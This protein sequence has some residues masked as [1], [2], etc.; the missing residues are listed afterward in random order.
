VAAILAAI[1]APSMRR[2]RAD[3]AAAGIDDIPDEPHRVRRERHDDTA[4][5]GSHETA[6]E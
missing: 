1:A 5:V 3:A 2:L 4:T 6:S